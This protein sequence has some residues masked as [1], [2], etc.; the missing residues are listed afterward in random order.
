MIDG[1]ELAEAA[2][3]RQRAAAD[4]A[5]AGFDCYDP[6]RVMRAR[7]GDIARRRS[8]S[9][10]T[11][12]GTWRA[13]TW[14]SSI[15]ICRPR[16]RPGTRRSSP[17]AR[18]SSRTRRGS[19]SS[20][21]ARRFAAAP[22]TRRSSPAASTTSTDALRY[23]IDHYGHGARLTMLA[24][25]AR[26]RRARQ[27]LRHAIAASRAAVLRLQLSVEARLP[28]GRCRRCRSRAA[29][30]GAARAAQSLHA[31]FRSAPTAA[32]SARSF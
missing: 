11:I 21:S 29:W 23:I 27:R 31:T 24:N 26:A 20:C 8:R 19:P 2:A 22:D 25:D 17:S 30:R 13:P 10:P 1:L 3:W 28:A 5:Q 4:L 9:S 6:T 14:C 18:C 16:S 32:P 12:A 7:P 15:S